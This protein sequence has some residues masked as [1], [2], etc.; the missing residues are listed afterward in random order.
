MTEEELAK[1]YEEATHNALVYGAGFVKV[2]L[3]KGVLEVSVVDP[4]DYR[5][6]EPIE[7]EAKLKEKNT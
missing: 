5:Y 6:I 2:A 1:T 7:A 4:R 3:V